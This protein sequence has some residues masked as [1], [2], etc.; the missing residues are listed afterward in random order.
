MTHAT[1]TTEAMTVEATVVV[2]GGWLA[3]VCM[4]SRVYVFVWVCVCRNALGLSECLYVRKTE[5]TN[6]EAIVVAMGGWL[7]CV[8]MCLCV[9]VL[10]VSEYYGSF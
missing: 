7:A 9:Y 8:C 6:V 1:H 5:A 2:M 3:C 4:C 10:C